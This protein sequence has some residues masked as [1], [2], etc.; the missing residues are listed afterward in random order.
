MQIHGCYHMYF[1]TRLITDNI[2]IVQYVGYT[3]ENNNEYY[4]I[5]I[6]QEQ[7][8][9][10]GNGNVIHC[11]QI[12]RNYQKDHIPRYRYDYHDMWVQ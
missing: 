6:G 12:N 8:A 9:E 7:M 3:D 5:K 2:Y 4:Y 11:Q 10:D 1:I